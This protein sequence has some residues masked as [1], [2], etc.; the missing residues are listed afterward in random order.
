MLQKDL[1]FALVAP[2]ILAP[3]GRHASGLVDDG[4]VPVPQASHIL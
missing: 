1:I 3:P 4:F 2:A